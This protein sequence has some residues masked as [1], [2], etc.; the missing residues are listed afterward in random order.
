MPVTE[1]TA[2]DASGCPCCGGISP[3]AV[4]SHCDAGKTLT[5]A[6]VTFAGF[7]SWGAPMNR[8]VI[9]E[10]GADC[11]PLSTCELYGYWDGI[12]CSGWDATKPRWQRVRLLIDTDTSMKVFLESPD[13]PDAEAD[14]SG[15]GTVQTCPGCNINFTDTPADNFTSKQCDEPDELE[16]P[17]LDTVYDPGISGS[18]F[19]VD[20][21][22]YID[23][24][25]VTATVTALST[26][27]LTATLTLTF[28]GTCAT[29]LG[30]TVTLTYDSGTATYTGS[31]AACNMD[32]VFDPCDGSLEGTGDCT[33]TGVG[34]I[35]DYSPYEA[36]GASLTIAP[37]C[38]CC[39]AADGLT[40]GWGVS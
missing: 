11:F 2:F 18:A 34:G 9:V 19:C 39:S 21:T 3:C 28:T 29:A 33:V 8:T 4:C 10:L 14:C 6:A 32:Y 40:T 15:A 30:T 5:Q 24:T 25:G 27:Y 31:S 12:S 13:V 26:A 20:G 38:A 17:N 37:G 23:L 22:D 16:I 35:I 7:T 36:G 1:V